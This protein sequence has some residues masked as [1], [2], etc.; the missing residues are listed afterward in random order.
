[1]HLLLF[2]QPVFDFTS[3]DVTASE[4]ADGRTATTSMSVELIPVTEVLL[5]R[6]ARGDFFSPWRFYTNETLSGHA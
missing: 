5:T 4:A 2:G 3:R 6:Y 1:L